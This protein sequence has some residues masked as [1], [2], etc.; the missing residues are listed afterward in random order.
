MPSISRQYHPP[1]CRLEITAK[2]SALSRWAQRP[3]LQSVNF[4]LSFPDISGKYHEPLEIRGNREQLQLLSETVTD[5]VQGMLGQSLQTPIFNSVAAPATQPPHQVEAKQPATVSDQEDVLSADAHPPILHSRSLLTHEL[6]LGALATNAEH[7]SV[8]LKTSQLFDLVSALDD[9]AGELEILP[10]PTP[11][12]KPRIPV[13]ASSA[14]VVVL[15]LG[16][17]TATLQITQHSPSET[18]DLV[19]STDQSDRPSPSA[20]V[21]SIASAPADSSKPKTQSP[22]TAPK[23]KAPS[24]TTGFK[25]SPLP[26]PTATAGT[27]TQESPETSVASPLVTLKPRQDRQAPSPTKPSE[28]LAQPEPEPPP[29]LPNRQPKDEGAIALADKPVRSQPGP[30]P[31]NP[32]S[33]N[34]KVPNRSIAAS[35]AAPKPSTSEAA[36]ANADTN[37]EAEALHESDH[38]DGS[39]ADADV[40]QSRNQIGKQAP[41]TATFAR[42]RDLQPQ[43]LEI[44]R[45]ISQRWQAPAG[46]TQ[47]LQYQL[48]L[49]SNGSLSQVN[50]LNSAA[51]QYLGQVPLPAVNQPFI[52]PSK[53]PSTD[54]VRL[55]LKPDGTVQTFVESQVKPPANK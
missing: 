33:L 23:P 9:C 20:E 11:T 46:L 51:A 4:L 32:T 14:A 5:Y 7:Q 45:Y 25:K 41:S 19:T 36:P 37:A 10:L 6:V 54:R 16:V 26:T 28:P 17:T 22:T 1:S 34:S 30:T 55:V 29:T 40:H 44:R 15:M 2:I 27:A 38:F 12:R 24:P 53:F 52:S 49:N 21:D 3:I 31:G 8:C 43:A 48:T 42:T 47:P 35:P 18:E 39:K 13:W 50:P